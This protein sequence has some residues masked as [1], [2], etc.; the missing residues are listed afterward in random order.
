[1]A[2]KSKDR[3]SILV[4]EDEADLLELLTF[5]LLK[6]GFDVRGADSGRMALDQ[7][8]ERPLPNLMLLDLM[9]PDGDGLEVCRKVKTDLRTA[10]VPIIIVTAK[11][12]EA[13]VVVGLE[14]GADDYVAKPFSVRV[15]ISRVRAVLRRQDDTNRPPE[16]LLERHGIRINPQR[17][18]VHLRGKPIELTYSEFNVLLLLARRPGWVHTR[19]QIMDAARGPD[20]D[21]T[22]RAM[23]VHIFNLRKKLTKAGR[24]IE[25]VRGV[26][27]RLVE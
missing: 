17:R 15:L 18:T 25:S 13:D 8:R 9:L 6:E 2:A 5:N 11:G 24:V 7:L 1:M 22:E 12:E 4:V 10:A 26:G 19:Q 14:L 20:H 27:Y 23:D 3:Q 16:Q 21:P